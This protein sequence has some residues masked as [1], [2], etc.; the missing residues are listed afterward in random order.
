MFERQCH[1]KPGFFFSFL[2][3]WYPALSISS[4]K[5]CN[6]GLL[7]L[8]LDQSSTIRGI[9]AVHRS[10]LVLIVNNAGSGINL[11]QADTPRGIFFIGLFEAGKLTLNVM[12][13]WIKGDGVRALV[14]ACLLSVLLVRSL[15]LFS[16]TYLFGV[17][18][19]HSGLLIPNS[20]PPD[21]FIIGRDYLPWCNLPLHVSHHLFVTPSVLQ[22][23]SPQ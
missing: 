22:L 4:P 10:W 14:F 20:N 5:W 19:F 9:Q 3:W 11:T 21:R 15:I 18:S 17:L 8:A 6:P 1:S 7:S 12:V 13:S 16:D 23:A 2:T